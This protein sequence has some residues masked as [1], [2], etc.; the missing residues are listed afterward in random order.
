VPELRDVR[1]A[2][3]VAAFERAGGVRRRGK[4]IVVKMPNGQT[5]AFSANR[6][7][8]KIGILKP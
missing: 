6:Q 7:P 4:H 8:I 2:D 5:L 3:A 1:V